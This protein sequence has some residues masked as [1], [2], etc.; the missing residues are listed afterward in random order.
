MTMNMN[1]QP[2]LSRPFPTEPILSNFFTFMHSFNRS[3]RLNLSRMQILFFYGRTRRIQI[4]TGIKSIA[5]VR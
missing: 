5:T 3:K 1:E 2:L 4:Q